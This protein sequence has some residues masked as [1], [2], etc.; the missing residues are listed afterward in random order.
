[1]VRELYEYPNKRKKGEI[2]ESIHNQQLESSR[3]KKVEFV[4]TL[5]SS[6]SGTKLS[7]AENEEHSFKLKLTCSILSIHNSVDRLLEK[8]EK[9]KR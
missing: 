3:G 5:A 1:M 7:P 6:V 4:E 8:I 2:I 9:I